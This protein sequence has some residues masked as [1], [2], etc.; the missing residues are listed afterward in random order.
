MRCRMPKG[1][2]LSFIDKCVLADQVNRA[3]EIKSAEMDQR[4][5]ERKRRERAEKEA[6]S[7]KTN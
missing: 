1:P 7:E 2:K 3:V 6:T 4:I 5:A